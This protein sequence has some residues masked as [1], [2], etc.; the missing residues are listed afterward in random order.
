MEKF[1][2]SVILP[3]KSSSHPWFEDYF[4]KAIISIKTQEVEINELIL[5]HTDET[6]LVEFLNE[7]DFSGINVTKEVWTKK[8]NFSEQ[9]NHGARVAKSKWISIFEFDD[10]YSKIW[11]KNVDKYSKVYKDVDCFLPIVVDVTENGQFA[12]FTNEATFAVNIS[13][14]IGILSNET[15]LSYQNFQMSGMV[16]KRSSFVDFGLLKPSFKLTFG[17]ELFLRLTHNSVK[18]MTIP[19]IGYK[20]TNLRQG[21][22]FW[23]YKNGDEVLDKEEIQFWIDSAKKESFFIVDRAIKYQS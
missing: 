12:G 4:N 22:I 3:L 2:L 18:I 16:I 7:Y 21:S 19:R 6:K 9:V 17:Y 15:L 8:P 5:V 1:D 23:D 13:S 11:F 20:H 14:E 10:E